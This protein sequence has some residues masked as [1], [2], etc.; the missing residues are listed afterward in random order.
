MCWSANRGALDSCHNGN[1]PAG[2]FTA[3]GAARRPEREFHPLN[4]RRRL[5]PP[6]PM[7]PIP[8]HNTAYD[9]WHEARDVDTAVDA[10]WQML[11]QRHLCPALH[12]ADKLVLET[13]CG[14]GGFACWLAQQ[15]PLARLV[16][17]ADFSPAAVRKGR[18]YARHLSL[19]NLR[20]CVSDIQQL[21]FPDGF[22]DTVFSL[23]TIEHVPAP[24]VAVSELARVLKPGG[25]MFL[26]APSY[27]N[28]LG[29]YRIWL[30]LT[31]RHF[32]EAGQ[33]VNQ[34]TMFPRTRGWVRRRGMKVITTDSMGV[35]LPWARR[36]PPGIELGEIRAAI[37]RRLGRSQ[38]AAGAFSFHRT[39]ALTRS[40]GLYSCFVAIKPNGK[41]V[42]TCDRTAVPAK[43]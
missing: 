8:D 31:G 17:A 33:P 26:T 29:L 42:V 2:K 1:E 9:S 11:V 43:S 41:P 20:W 6:S 12:L 35:Y 36:P 25:T 30:R 34:F 7:N 24:Q 5:P 39:N 19:G 40:L 13:G 38:R 16:C 21:P 32:S 3:F 4:L 22:F 18:D 23:E 28:W 27:L 37:S 10:P 15:R 14:R